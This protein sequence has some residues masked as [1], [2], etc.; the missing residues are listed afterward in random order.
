M[1]ALAKAFKITLS[2]HKMDKIKVYFYSSL[3]LFSM[4]LTLSPRV[5]EAAAPLDTVVAVV[6][7][8]VITQSELDKEVSYIKVQLAHNSTPL[9]TKAELESQVLNRMIDQKL[10]LQM[11]AKLNI[12]I[13]DRAL[14]QAMDKIAAKNQMNIAALKQTLQKDSINYDFYRNQV[15]EQLIVQQLLQREVAP[16][17]Y[18]ISKQDIANILNSKGYQ[19]AHQAVEYNIEDIL[20]ALPDEPS[21]DELS[22]ANKKADDIV[23]QL[24]AGAN[25]NQLAVAQSNG[26]EALQG[27]A[28]GWRTPEELPQVFVNA[29]KGLNEGEVSTPLRTGNGIH[30]L[31]L[32]GVKNNNEKHTVHETQVRHILIKTDAVHSD[33]TVRKQLLSL[34]SQ[35]DSGVSFEQL[36]EKYSQDPTSAIKGGDLGWVQP[37][38]LVPPF[39]KAMDALPLKQVSAPVKS[40]YGWHLIEVLARKD[41]DN[42]QEYRELQVKRMLFESRMDEKTQDWLNRMRAST[43]I[44]IY[45]KDD[46]T[47]VK[48]T[49]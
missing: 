32:V 41:R 2:G 23:R 24:K 11:A 29:V 15:R 21:S 18:D 19:E 22:A 34:K 13:D 16:R 31:H 27:G 4:G 47:P 10:E 45:L 30:V 46:A 44:K 6:G 35:M 40:E 5:V 14:D 12:S 43:Y 7:D 36:A 48:T 42:T 37:G 26:D 1:I 49:P 3:L 9:P 20:I 17:V 33:E 28:L 38:T 8:D 39:E 25:F